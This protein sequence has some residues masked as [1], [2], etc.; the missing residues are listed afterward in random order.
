MRALVFAAGLGTRLK[1]ITDTVP[2][3]L[4]PVCSKPLLGHLVEKL[5]QNGYGEVVINLHHFPQQ[6]KDYVEQNGS[7][8]IKVSF[9]DESDLLRETGGGIRHAAP[10]LDDGEPFLVHNVDIISIV[11]SNRTGKD[12]LL[13]KERKHLIQKP[14]QK[15]FAEVFIISDFNTVLCRFGFLLSFSFSTHR[16]IRRMK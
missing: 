2:K 14:R 10:L 1:P 4:V 11:I 13:Q 5:K 3:A 9:S 8:G 16:H 15:T 6:I 7:F 12:R